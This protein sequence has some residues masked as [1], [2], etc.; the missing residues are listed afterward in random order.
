MPVLRF[1]LLTINH[2]I[3][4]GGFTVIITTNAACHLYLRYSDIFPRIHRKPVERRGLVMGWDARYCFTVYQHIEQNEAGDTWTHTYTWPGWE[5]CHTRYFYFW[6]TMGGQDMVSETPIFWLHYLWVLPPGYLLRPNGIGDLDNHLQLPDT[7]EHWEKVDEV[8]ANDDANYVY[9]ATGDGTVD[10]YTIEPHGLPPGTVI[11]SLT[12]H[13]R[14][15]RGFAHVGHHAAANWWLKTLG[16]EKNYPT[17]YIYD[18]W[19][20]D[21]KDFPLNPVSSAP[22]TL[23]QLTDL[24]IGTGLSYTSTPK[25]EDEGRNTQ[26]YLDVHFT[27]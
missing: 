27:L 2:Y 4:E 26:L 22:W 3:W 10:L 14:F 23:A 15:Y 16:M 17:A 24:Q 9:G 5:D 18:R 1:H 13:G 21:S 11:D 20:T 6:G 19:Y 7:G 25:K 8:I 12:F